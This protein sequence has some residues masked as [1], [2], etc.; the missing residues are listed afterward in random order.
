MQNFF[1]AAE[2]KTMAILIR[3]MAEQGPALLQL[4]GLTAIQCMILEYLFENRARDVFQRDLE[5]E[6]RIRRSTVTGILQGMERRGLI[7][8]QP[9]KQDARLKKLVL[10]D[11]GI[12]IHTNAE[13]TM[14]EVERRALAGISEEEF[15][16]FRST[17]E[18]I[19]QNLM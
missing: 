6:F 5:A 10:T 13:Q 18:K 17:L 11:A 14:R 4:D 1:L 19:K 2:L 7:L 3:R 16:I 12:G 15:L 9:V 8:R